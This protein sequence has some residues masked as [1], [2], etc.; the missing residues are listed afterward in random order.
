MIERLQVGRKRG[1][2]WLHEEGG[3]H[4]LVRCGSG[5]GLLPSALN[6]FALQNEVGEVLV[7]LRRFS[8][9]RLQP[10]RDALQNVRS[11][12]LQL[13][14]FGLLLE[15]VPQIAKLLIGQ[16]GLLHGVP[17]SL[18]GVAGFVLGRASLEVAL[19]DGLLG[20]GV[21]LLDGAHNV[22]HVE[23]AGS[24]DS[25]RESRGGVGAKNHAVHVGSQH[26]EQ[27][28][29]AFLEHRHGVADQLQLENGSRRGLG[30]KAVLVAL[31]K[32]GGRVEELESD[33]A[34]VGRGFIR[35]D[36]ATHGVFLKANLGHGRTLEG[37]QRLAGVHVAGF[38][39]PENLRQLEVGAAL[40][41][42]GFKQR[43]LLL[44]QRV[45]PSAGCTVA[46]REFRALHRGGGTADVGGCGLE[47]LAE[48]DDVALVVVGDGVSGFDL[49]G[50]EH[51]LL[52]D[53]PS[54]LVEELEA[55]IFQVF[56]FGSQGA[57]RFLSLFLCGIL[58]LWE[59]SIIH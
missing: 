58:L 39:K 41:L 45:Q 51:N 22:A 24:Q 54:C 25:T 5:F 56:I 29:V 48:R 10:P 32:P 43:F 40:L 3:R 1:L 27:A 50:T 26:P 52:D 59:A 4:V 17:D 38:T 11:L 53:F 36:G 42:E 33:A 46:G 30:A 16:F 31:P 19:D 13:L 34:S 20:Q 9:H 37:H 55:A 44:G 57:R 28:V 23:A 21:V 8:A 6:R 35:D 49:F 12:R 18:H 2:I 15:S 47:P 14:G 7:E